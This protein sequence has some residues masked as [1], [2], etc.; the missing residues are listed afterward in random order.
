MKSANSD[1][2]DALQAR[3][4]WLAVI[5]HWTIALVLAFQL[6]LGFAMPKDGSGFALYQLHK[7]V[8]IT[9]LLLSLARLA[10][11]LSHRQPPP[12]G[13]GFSGR[14]A[15]AVHALLYV[16]MIATPLAGWALVSSAPVRIP[17]LLYG[18]LPWPHL[19]LPGGV[20]DAAKSAHEALAWLG[21][22]L[23][24]LHV[25]GALRH[26]LLLKDGL[27]VRIAPGGRASLAFVLLT[28]FIAI[29]FGTGSY[30]ARKDL[31]PALAR[32][33]AARAGQAAIPSQRQARTLESVSLER[34]EEAVGLKVD[35]PLGTGVPRWSIQPGGRLEFALGGGDMQ[36]RGRFSDWSGTIEFDPERPETANIRIAVRL[37]SA[38][39]GDSAMDAT[40]RGADFLA[41]ASGPVATW[42][43]TAIRRAGPRR[44]SASGML[45]LKGVTR[46]QM[47]TFAL[48]GNG[49]R[50]RVEGSA[51]I[52]R[53]AFGVGTGDTAA[54][55]SGTVT[56]SFAF[57]AVG[58]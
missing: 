18:L 45:T 17:T 27:L 49:S 50:R 16:F 19:P 20:N 21:L 11:R 42:H 43:A 28:L 44:Y 55:L 15:A 9:V 26:Q 51:Q 8:G 5:L 14:L 31:V 29:Y 47:L 1:R 24:V 38:T 2:Y 4:S 37:A 34:P 41:A 56:L 33:E 7:S 6:A 30:V 58:G 13:R 39:V 32:Q 35:E 57:D 25:A 3:Y 12:V 10:W 48:Q 46:L 23:I 54:G 22:G 52:D 40:L 53:T 36:V